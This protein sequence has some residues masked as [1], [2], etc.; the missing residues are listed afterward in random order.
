MENS[1]FEGCMYIEKL[2]GVTTPV[3]IA[4]KW[5]H[6][7]KQSVRLDPEPAEN[8]LQKSKIGHPKQTEIAKKI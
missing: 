3:P 6:T 2:E 7:N 8:D 5:R 4:P 1:N